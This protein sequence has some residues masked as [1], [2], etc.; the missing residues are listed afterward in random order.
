[1]VDSFEAVLHAHASDAL[2]A[3]A[4]LGAKIPARPRTRE[5]VRV[6][7]VRSAKAGGKPKGKALRRQ[8]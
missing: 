8:R 5:A 6:K 7:S 3:S 2:I 4:H 1:L